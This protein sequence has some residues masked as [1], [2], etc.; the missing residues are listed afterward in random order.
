MWTIR[1]NVRTVKGSC[2]FSK[3]VRESFR[4]VATKCRNKLLTLAT[5]LSNPPLPVD[6]CKTD[7][8]GTAR[9]PGVYVR[10]YSGEVVPATVSNT[11]VPVANVM[12]QGRPSEA[13]PKPDCAVVTLPPLPSYLHREASPGV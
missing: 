11:A 8:Q 10:C 7:T 2:D 12:Q 1:V 9:F 5:Q 4:P 6:Y 13:V 3:C